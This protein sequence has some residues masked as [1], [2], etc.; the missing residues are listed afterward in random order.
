MT[1]EMLYLV[2]CME[3][4]TIQNITIVGIFTTPASAAKAIQSDILEIAGYVCDVDESKVTD[5]DFSITSE[6]FTWTVTCLKAD[7]VANVVRRS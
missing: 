3:A 4:A 6:G 2:L 1:N 5:G 7:E